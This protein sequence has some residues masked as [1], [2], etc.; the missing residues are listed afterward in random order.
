MDHGPYG[1]YCFFGGSSEV[2]DVNVCKFM[3]C[4]FTNKRMTHDIASQ[5]VLGDYQTQTQLLRLA[6]IEC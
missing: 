1:Q 6:K 2:F 5:S 3:Q 4:L